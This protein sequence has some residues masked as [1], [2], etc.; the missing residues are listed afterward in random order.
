MSKIILSLIVA[1]S[2]LFTTKVFASSAISPIAIGL[3]P[4]IQFPSDEFTITGL[5]A[6]VLWG[7]HR[8]MYGLDFGV[9]GNITDQTY[10]GIG[11]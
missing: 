6:S 3:V 8:D 10:T 5:R 7:H 9:L 1:C 11:V 4:P 2:V